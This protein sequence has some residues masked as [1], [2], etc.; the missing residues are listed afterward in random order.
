MIAI[1]ANSLGSSL[2]KDKV[3][4]NGYVPYI[5][6]K[7][8]LNAYQNLQDKS[9]PAMMSATELNYHKLYKYFQN[10]LHAL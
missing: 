1:P 2:P 10:L 8:N 5:L 4:I 9:A 3:N 6:L 7:R